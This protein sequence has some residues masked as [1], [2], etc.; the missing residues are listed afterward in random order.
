VPTDLRIGTLAWRA[1]LQRQEKPVL[2]WALPQSAYARGVT[3]RDVLLI[4]SR[5]MVLRIVLIARP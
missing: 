1:I 3:T 5:E 4:E 2:T